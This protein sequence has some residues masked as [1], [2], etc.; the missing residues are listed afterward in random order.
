MINNDVIENTQEKIESHKAA[1]PMKIVE[2]KDHDLW[3][4]DENVHN[5]ENLRE[6]NCWR[7]AEM[8]FTRND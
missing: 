4:C 1:R 8:A 5:I 7:C 2:D 3:L 6:Q